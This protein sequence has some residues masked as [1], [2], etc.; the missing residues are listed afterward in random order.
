MHIAS[1]RQE[2]R[3]K[4]GSE[5]KPITKVRKRKRGDQLRGVQLLDAHAEAR[6]RGGP[7]APTREILA[8][9]IEPADD[10]PY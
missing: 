3:P 9:P 7:G 8:Y 5:P 2:L 10:L 1:A 4:H 6:R